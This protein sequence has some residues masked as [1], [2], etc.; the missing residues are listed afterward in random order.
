MNYFALFTWIF[1]IIIA[2]TVNIIMW[3]WEE[4]II[5]MT[6]TAPLLRCRLM[7]VSH[8]SYSLGT[9]SMY[10]SFLLTASLSSVPQHL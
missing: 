3:E 1:S 6:N 8:L 10:S 9:S 5:H 4:H 2:L 7:L